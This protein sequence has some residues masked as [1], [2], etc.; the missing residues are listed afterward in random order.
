MIS[1]NNELLRIQKEIEEKKKEL[2]EILNIHKLI[3]KSNSETIEWDNLTEKMYN[4]LENKIH[5]YIAK[6]IVWNLFTFSLHFI[7][8]RKYWLYRKGNIGYS[9]KC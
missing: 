6:S 1:L 9:K 4:K 5:S 8:E 2:N 3:E 7:I